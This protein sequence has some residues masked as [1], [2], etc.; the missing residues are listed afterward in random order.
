MNGAPTLDM[1]A[2]APLAFAAFGA[3]VVLM[4]EV[5]LT[6]RK[7]FLGRPATEYFIGV[8]LSVIAMVFLGLS[9]YCAGAAFAE[10]GTRIFDAANP[11]VLLDRFGTYSMALVGVASILV[12]L[13][14]ISYLAQL[15]IN[16]GEFYA[17]LLLSTSGMFLLVGAVDLMA[18]FLGIELM[19]IPLYVMAGFDRRN[20]RSNESAFKYFLVGSFASAILLYG[21]ALIYGVTGTLEFAGIQKGF[22]PGNPLGMVGL[23][24]L[25][26]GFAFK[27]A[28]VPFHQWAPD[29]Y[30]G[31]P[32]AVTAYMA[33]TVKVAAFVA[34]LRLLVQ[35]FGPVTA[36]LVDLFWILAILTILVGNVMALIQ[37]NLKRLLAYSSIAHAGY[38]LIGF[39]TGTIEGYGA[40][41]FYLLVYVFTNIGAF[42]VLIALTQDRRDCDS[43]DDLTGLARQRPGLAALLTLFALSLAGIPGTAG[44]FAKFF[45]FKAAVGAGQ[46]VL[47]LVGVLGS[48]IS[49]YYYLRLPVVMYFGD[50]AVGATAAP[51]RRD[52]S[53]GEALVLL[54]CAAIVLLLGFFPTN[55]P[56]LLGGLRPLEWARSGVAMLF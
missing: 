43:F 46:T 24:M 20:L 48:V 25:I 2:I 42:A 54:L 7:H 41:L 14:S 29:V 4:G 35:A 23:A 6:R 28:T 26:V 30:E 3:L 8:V 15:G 34:L 17:L 10:G 12:C 33:T 31:A 47:A 1:A 27:V 37:T 18:L 55:A 16:H 11:M 19:S 5:W 9:V 44:F 32:T 45:L 51:R 38:L 39:A 52:V 50:A 49:V 56:Q 40:V 13:L 22:P 36:S 21:I 53:T